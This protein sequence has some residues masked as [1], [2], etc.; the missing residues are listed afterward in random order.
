MLAATSYSDEFF[1]FIS[2]NKYADPAI[3]IMKAGKKQYDFDIKDAAQQILCRQKSS[4]K[5]PFFLSN[6]RFLFPD[7]ISSEQASDERVARFH[8]SLIGIDK[9]VIDLTAGLGID[10]MS[11]AMNKN[12]VTAVELDQTKAKALEHNTLL[13][14]LSSFK[15]VNM[16]CSDFLKTLDEYPD[17][18]FIDPARRDS[19]NRRTY[20]FHDC[21]PDVTAIY[22]DLIKEGSKLLIKASPLLDISAVLKELE[23]VEHIYAVAVKGEC[24]EILIQVSCGKQKD[25]DVLLTAIDLDSSGIRSEFSTEF[26]SEAACAPLYEG[27]SIPEGFYLY[28]PNAALMKLQASNQICMVFPDMRKAARNTEVYF[29]RE[30]HID[31]PGRIVSINK[32]LSSGDLKKIKS[33]RYSVVCRNY[34]VKSED[35]RKKYKLKESDSRFLYGIRIGK[36][37]KP[38]LI[39][40]EKLK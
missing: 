4:S 6:N 17:Y 33:E 31:F 8:A 3:L 39:E 11:I 40:G 21:Q 27:E 26:K 28:E 38:I 14:K 25:S 22:K 13:F 19:T 7:I 24:K 1:N 5:I 12:K 34:P 35:I 36:F 20:S 37:E 15:V 29:S 30:L 2:D 16:E 9:F 10:S 32:I 23:G 18:F